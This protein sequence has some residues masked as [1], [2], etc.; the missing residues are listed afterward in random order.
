M[1]LKSLPYRRCVGCFIVNRDNKVF[2][3]QRADTKV[4]AWQMPQGG[5]DED[6]G[7]TEAALREAYEE[8]GLKD[9]DVLYESKKWHY[10]DLPANFVPKLWGGKYRGQKQKWFLLRHSGDDSKVCLDIGPQE[11]KKWRWVNIKLL[12]SLAISFKKKIY[13]SISDEFTRFLS[14][15]KQK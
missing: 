14:E 13:S 4:K 15:E 10:Y 3:G 8:T 9:L 7:S 6:E 12:P 1:T 11:F 5:I 2:V